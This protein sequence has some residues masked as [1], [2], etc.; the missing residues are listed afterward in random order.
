MRD[1]LLGATRRPGVRPTL[2]FAAPTAAVRARTPRYRLNA[3]LSHLGASAV[4][5]SH[6]HTV[7]AQGGIN[8]ALSNMEED[9]WRYHMYD[10][11]KGS[12]WL[13]DQDA[14]QYMCREAPA[15]GA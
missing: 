12:D 15:T 4:C 10:T 6:S 13:G 8:A 1:E 7:A 2:R 3:P 11:V 9:D 14:I 5:A